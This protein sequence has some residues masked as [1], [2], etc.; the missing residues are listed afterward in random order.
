MVSGLRILSPHP[1]ARRDLNA[2]LAIVAEAGTGDALADFAQRPA[3]TS[4]RV[5]EVQLAAEYR[6]IVGPNAYNKPSSSHERLIPHSRLW[7][8][9]AS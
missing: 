8:L 5:A 2:T 9:V 3:M 7:S 4:L 6:A 1:V